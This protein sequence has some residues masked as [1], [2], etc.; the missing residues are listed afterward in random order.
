MW[1]DIA[2]EAVVNSPPDACVQKA[3][4]LTRYRIKGYYGGGLVAGCELAYIGRL[5]LAGMSPLVL[6]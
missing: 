4:E 3:A 6:V 1:G 2:T 5:F